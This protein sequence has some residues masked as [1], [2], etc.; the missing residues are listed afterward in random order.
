MAADSTGALRSL[1]SRIGAVLQQVRNDAD[2][3]RRATERTMRDIDRRL[4]HIAFLIASLDLRV[5]IPKLAELASMFPQANPPKREGVCDRISVDF[6]PTDEY[7]A[8]ARVC[9][10]M[11]PLPSAERLRVTFSVVMLP[12]HLPY[13]REAWIDLLVENP[14]LAA[15]GEFLDARI[16]QFVSDYVRVRDPES[17][18][19][20]EQKVTDPVCK[21]TFSLA[22][23]A[24]SVDWNGK[25]YYFCV[26]SC[27]RRFEAAPE[28]YVERP[29]A[30]KDLPSRERS[31]LLD[32]TPGESPP[33]RPGSRV[34]TGG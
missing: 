11:T 8:Q 34:Q 22:E 23:A 30:V 17:P 9:V 19:H 32:M 24:T 1:A 29:V 7:P 18:Y 13:Q 21:M 20:D 10:G 28:R 12:V 2:H 26:E 16:M 4:K 6:L 14:D 5:V 27:A 25:N 33:T 15:L 3:R 31:P